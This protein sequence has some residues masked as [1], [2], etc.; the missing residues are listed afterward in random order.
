LF[1]IEPK[2]FDANNYVILLVIKT[3]RSGFFEMA[4]LTV[5]I[6]ADYFH[7]SHDC[8]RMV[9]IQL[10]VQF[11]FMVA[12]PVENP[13]FS[14][15]FLQTI[16]FVVVGVMFYWLV[17]QYV[18]RFRTTDNN[19]ISVYSPATHTPNADTM[20]LRHSKQADMVTT[21]EQAVVDTANSTIHASAVDRFA[22][23]PTHSEQLDQ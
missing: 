11:L 10:I 4:L 18:V 14:V 7:V 22:D 16:S 12:N 1:F 13:F 6:P 17:A 5:S 21:P 19:H 15:A 2:R 9:C 3:K 23:T 8:L 20:H